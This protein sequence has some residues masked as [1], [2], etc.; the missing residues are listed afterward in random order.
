MRMRRMVVLLLVVV[1]AGA[2]GQE[3]RGAASSRSA[4]AARRAAAA[5]KA[6]ENPPAPVLSEDAAWARGVLVGFAALVVAAVVVGP[7][8]RVIMPGEQ[9]PSH[10]HDE[11]PGSSRRHGPGG[12]RARPEE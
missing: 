12:E 5:A 9:V 8:Y 3:R 6:V 10:S 11:P 4:R 1:C 2:F 7:L